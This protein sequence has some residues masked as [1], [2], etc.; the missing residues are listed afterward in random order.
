LDK[1]GTTLT[2]QDY[3]ETN[4]V[5]GVKNE[6]GDMVIRPLTEDEK[7]WLSQFVAE[8]DHGNF[9]KNT[10]LKKEEKKLRSMRTDYRYLKKKE[11]VDEMAKLYP[12]IQSQY[13]LVLRLRAETNAFYVTDT[14]RHELYDRDYE[15]RMDVFNNAKISDNL[16]L[17]DLTE[18]DKFSTEAISDINPEDLCLNHLDYTPK[19]KRKK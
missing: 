14:E 16:V 2:R 15:R 17:Y 6:K 10:Q 18:Y 8:T 11:K 4:Y 1:K 3:I 19:K 9:K 12:K 5:N 7:K 13:E